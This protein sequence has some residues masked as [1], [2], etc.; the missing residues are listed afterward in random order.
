MPLKGDGSYYTPR[1]ELEELLKCFP[2]IV[3]VFGVIRTSSVRT[4][5]RC[6]KRII[7][8]EK[9][10]W[11]EA[12]AVPFFAAFSYGKFTEVGCKPVPK[13]YGG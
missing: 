12:H 1:I 3:G 8:K 7:K 11:M 10:G 4:S 9:E 13:L 5:G 2:G 6:S